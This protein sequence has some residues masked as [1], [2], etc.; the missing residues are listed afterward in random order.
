MGDGLAD[1]SALELADH[2]RSHECSPVEVV[3]AVLDRMEQVDDRVHA[4]VA[5]AADRARDEA[6]RCEAG[7][8]GDASDERSPL[9]GVPITVKD[10]TATEG[11]VTTRGSRR[12][13]STTAR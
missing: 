12:Y 2:Y 13:A 6:R 5:V 8:L 10:I 4:V 3:E 9:F 11:I 1:L 7:L